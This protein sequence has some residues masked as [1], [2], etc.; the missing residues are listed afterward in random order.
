MLLV[1][2]GGGETPVVLYRALIKIEGSEPTVAVEMIDLVRQV[3]KVAVL[4][5]HSDDSGRPVLT[6]TWRFEFEGADAQDIR[7]EQTTPSRG[8]MG[9]PYRFGRAVAEAAGWASPPADAD[10]PS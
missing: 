8:R 10:P 4:E 1:L 3:S 6:T 9:Q 2:H 5:H 7:D